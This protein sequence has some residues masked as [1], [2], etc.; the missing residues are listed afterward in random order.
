MIINILHYTGELL[1][2]E[3]HEKSSFLGRV[4]TETFVHFCKLKNNRQQLILRYG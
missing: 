3:K 4:E 2:D 1:W